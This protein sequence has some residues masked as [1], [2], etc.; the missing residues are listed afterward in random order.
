MEFGVCWC[1]RYRKMFVSVV[2]GASILGPGLVEIEIDILILG[3]IIILTVV[4]LPIQASG[5]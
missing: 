4:I 5:R 1:A 3:R 2:C